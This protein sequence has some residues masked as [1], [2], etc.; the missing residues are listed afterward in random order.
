LRDLYLLLVLTFLCHSVA[1]GARVAL[2]LQAISLGAST[3]AVGVL[4]GIYGVLP[5]LSAV[6]AG[7]LSD[8][9]GARIPMLIGSA[10]IVIGA[11]IPY[12]WPSL[13]GLYGGSLFVGSGFMLY[14]VAMQNIAGH[15]GK[16]EDRAKNLSLMALGFSFSIMVGPMLAGV[17]IDAIGYRNTFLLFALM[18]IFPVAAIASGLLRLP[19]VPPPG[20]TGTKPRVLDLL[21]DPMLLKIFVTSALLS[22]AWELYTFVIPIY[23]S[24]IGLSPTAIGLIMGSFSAAILVVR[25]FLPFFAKRLDALRV[26]A[27]TL[28]YSAVL[29]V[30]FPLSTSAWLLAV[31]SFLLGLGLGIPQPLVVVL[32]HNSVPAGRAGEAIGIRQAIIY[33]TQAFMPMLFGAAGT[34]FGLAFVF[35]ASAVLFAGGSVYGRRRPGG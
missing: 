24:A 21:K 3:L 23:G 26:I 31:L 29:Y 16:P 14:N 33:A 13:P 20:T 34:A 11:I 27:A 2:S 4:L 15:I 18:P 28:L 35:W 9:I 6:P 30:F 32:L 8:R 12:L 19:D 1:S 5:M 10:G 7:R 22:V 17:S 25:V